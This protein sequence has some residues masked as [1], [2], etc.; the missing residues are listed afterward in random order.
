MATVKKDVLYP[1][2]YTLPD[3]RTFECKSEDVPY[4]AKRMNDMLAAGLH[5]P[6]AWAHQSTAVPMSDEQWDTYR[7]EKAKLVVGHAKGAELHPDG[8]LENLL[9]IP[10]DRDRAQLPKTRYVSPMI[11][12]D[13]VDPSGRKWDGP[14]IMHIA[15]T[16]R[17][18]QTKQQ[19][20]ASGAGAAL[21]FCL[22]LDGFRSDLGDSP[23]AKKPAKK[24]KLAD[25]EEDPKK[26][27]PEDDE[28]PPED[29]KVDEEPEDDEEDEEEPEVS[30][31]PPTKTPEEMAIIN[32]RMQDVIAKL[33][34]HQ[35]MVG[36]EDNQPKNLLEFLDRLIVALDTK[37]HTEDPNAGEQEQVQPEEPPFMMDMENELKAQKARGDNLERILVKSHRTSAK[38]RA[39]KLLGFL[40][41][42]EVDALCEAIDKDPINLSD[43]APT[44]PAIAQL[45][46]YE[47]AAKKLQKA[48]GKT[49][50][51]NLGLDDAEVVEPPESMVDKE[52]RA[53]E[54]GKKLADMALGRK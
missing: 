38:A 21:S 42:P 13:F 37:K 11:Q 29:D 54:Q 53:K 12:S 47:R 48:G 49:N 16:P 39:R 30:L 18:I 7:A 8:F 50:Q 1:G 15:V 22:S 23:V 45:E 20:F 31:E 27:K 52:K 2:I 24:V 25:D 36:S 10:D 5:I 46:A 14:S 43:D 34:E 9:E 6:V 4:F 33:A 40:D 51:F 19:P 41:K 44:S 17:P 28:P 35:I 3:G 26:K 32:K